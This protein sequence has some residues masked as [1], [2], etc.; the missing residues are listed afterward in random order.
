MGREDQHRPFAILGVADGDLV[1]DQANLDTAVGAAA[2]AL[3]PGSTGQV[4]HQ[5]LSGSGRFRW[6]LVRVRTDS[7]GF[8]AAACRWLKISRY[9]WVHRRP[10]QGQLRRV[11]TSKALVPRRRSVEKIGNS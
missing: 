6:T 5:L 11:A 9:R 1:V 7:T 4:H 10:L 8:S 2:G 3:A